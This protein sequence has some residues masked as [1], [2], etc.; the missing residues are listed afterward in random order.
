MII[1]DANLFIWMVT[2]PQTDANSALFR[3]SD[4]FFSAAEREELTF[5]TSEAIIA[6]AVWVL[7]G[8][9][10]IDR[11]DIAIRLSSLLRLRGC[12]MPTRDLC[13]E[14]LGRW[15]A[16]RRVSFVD[17]LAARMAEQSGNQLATLDRDLFRHTLAAVWQPIAGGST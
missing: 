6:E 14:A 9:Y 15:K 8:R 13:I 10:G 16:S 4:A 2:G 1:A 3:Y 17:C 11:A 5:T 7:A 12:N